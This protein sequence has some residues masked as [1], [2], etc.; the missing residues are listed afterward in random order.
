MPLDW[1]SRRF[2]EIH[3]NFHVFNPFPIP[4]PDRQNLLWQR[5]V[6]LAGRMAAADERFTAWANQVGVEYGPLPEETRKDM[7]H[8][9]DAVV[10]HLYELSA[11]QLTHIFETFHEGWEYQARLT[12]TLNH[13]N[14]WQT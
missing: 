7:I 14:R 12:V 8:E 4:R 2:V 5:V 3:L 11:E 9:L 1:Y 10:A 6:A 13:Y